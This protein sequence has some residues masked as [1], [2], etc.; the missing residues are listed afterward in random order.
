[1]LQCF[2]SLLHFYLLIYF[3]YT[4]HRTI[5]ERSQANIESAELSFPQ[6]ISDQGRAKIRSM[7]QRPM[8]L[9]SRMHMFSPESF[10]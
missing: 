2:V 3:L 7:A 4:L 9:D 10:D 6:D 8:R 1:M 5:P